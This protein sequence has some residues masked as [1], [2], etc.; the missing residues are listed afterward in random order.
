MGADTS[1]R[2]YKVMELCNIILVE[3]VDEIYQNLLYASSTDLAARTKEDKFDFDDNFLLE[4][5]QL[6]IRFALRVWTF[7]DTAF[8]E[9]DIDVR[10]G[11]MESTASSLYRNS[12]TSTGQSNRK[13]H[14]HRADIFLK[15]A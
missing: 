6:S 3:S 8:D 7:I 14:D 12:T 2:R 15:I 5:A 10:T 13:K 4:W 9:A 11:E 1:T